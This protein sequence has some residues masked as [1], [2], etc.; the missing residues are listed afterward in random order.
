MTDGGKGS[1]KKSGLKTRIVSGLVLAPVSIALILIGGWP[2]AVWVFAAALLA[3]YE[4]FGLV[5][6]SRHTF[7]HLLFGFFYF[8]VCFGSFL[9]L[10]FAFDQGGW[11]ALSVMLAV[12]SSDTGAYF[13]GKTIGGAKLA[14]R[15]SPN[16]TWA[17]LGGSMFFCGLT[18][19]LLF[20][21]ANGLAPDLNAGLGLDQ[22]AVWGI[23]ST[24]LILG[25]VGQAGDLLISFYKRRAHA[26]DTGHLIPGHGGLLDRIDALLLVSPVFLGILILCL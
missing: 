15:L 10:R 5:H 21:T 16:K 20:F 18:L 12:W 6:G 7:L 8:G 14:P 24:G 17:G 4:F 3:L 2:F 23:F 25:A 26:K 13:T 9:F 1:A 11:L 19:V 22:D